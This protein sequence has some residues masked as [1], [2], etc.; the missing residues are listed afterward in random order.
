MK[1]KQLLPIKSLRGF[2][3]VTLKTNESKT[4]SLKLSANDFKHYDE[5]SD[6]FIVEPG[7]YEIQVGASSDDIRLKTMLTIRK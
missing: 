3:R 7:Y 6:D 5:V 1:S 2:K 4:I